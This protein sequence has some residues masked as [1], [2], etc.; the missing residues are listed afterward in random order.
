[1]K[2]FLLLLLTCLF[3]SFIALSCG[4]GV[5]AKDDDSDTQAQDEAADEVQDSEVS[6]VD[7]IADETT[8]ETVDEADDSELPDE[9]VDDG[10]TPD[11]GEFQKT[12]EFDFS[13]DGIINVDLSNYMSIKGGAGTVNFSHNGANMTY[14]ELTVIIVQLFPIAI[15]QGGNVAIMWLESAPGIG[16]ETKQVFGFT[17][18]ATMTTAGNYTMEEVQAYA[19][20]GDINIDLQNGLFD[21]KCV[22]SAAIA[23]NANFAAVDAASVT[24]SASG[25]LRDPAAAGSQLPYPVCP[26]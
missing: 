24:L 26:E 9:T 25:E 18:P 22:R 16:A 10:E 6:D 2:R 17:Y 23:G 14:A 15:L 11:D 7:E 20:Y 19:F 13:F 8:D 5:D 3:I 12:G 1:M 4:D 21:I